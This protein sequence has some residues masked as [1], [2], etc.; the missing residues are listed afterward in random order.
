MASVN[1]ALRRSDGKSFHSPGNIL[2]KTENPPFELLPPSLSG[3]ITV[4]DLNEFL[5]Q[6]DSGDVP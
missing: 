1:V 5:N 6:G 2:E 4:N 3:G